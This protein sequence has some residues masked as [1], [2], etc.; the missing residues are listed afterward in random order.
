MLNKGRNVD[1][2]TNVKKYRYGWRNLL[3]HEGNIDL[4]TLLR[5]LFAMFVGC[6]ANP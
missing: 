3:S 1:R 4:G 5:Y 2:G 6:G